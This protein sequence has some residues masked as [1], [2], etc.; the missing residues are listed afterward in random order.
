[1]GDYYQGLALGR[2]VGASSYNALVVSLEKRMAHG[3]TV[4]GGHRWSKCLNESEAAFF[5]R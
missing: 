2:N 3:L 4:L 1:M 5:G